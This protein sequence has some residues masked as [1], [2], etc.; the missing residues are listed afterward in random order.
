M[1]SGQFHL[2]PGTYLDAVRAEV[3]A[4][5]EFQDAVAEA[6]TP[7]AAR[8]I[9]ELG[10]GTGE[11]ALRVLRRH[12]S[13]RLVGLDASAEMVDVASRVLPTA[14]LRVGY[15]EEP[16]PEGEFDLVVSALAVHHLTSAGKADLFKRVG[17]QLVVGGRFVLG[18]VIVPD[19]PEDAETPLEPE[20]DFPDRLQDQLDWLEDAG[21]NASVFWVHKD[22]AVVAADRRDTNKYEPDLLGRLHRRSQRYLRGSTFPLRDRQVPTRVPPAPSS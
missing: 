20:V 10:V 15:L 17:G 7:I 2:D 11:T 14:D 18:D 21:L 19:R 9:L 16:L 5:D 3:P 13:A 4:Y 8:C 22:L 6:A 12:P 1:S